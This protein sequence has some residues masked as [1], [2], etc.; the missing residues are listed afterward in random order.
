MFDL[1]DT[2][3]NRKQ[4]V[5]N[6]FPLIIEKCYK[7]IAL[8]E[9]QYCGMLKTFKE[10]DQNGRSDKIKMFGSLF[11]EFPPLYRLSDSEIKQFW[12][13]NFYDCFTLEN[14]YKNVLKQLKEHVKTAVITNGS[15]FSQ[16]SKI[17]NT[18][19]DEFF[20]VIIVS[21]EAELWKPDPKIFELALDKLGVSPENA[22]FVGDNLLTD[23]AGCQSAGIN[24]IWFN[25]DKAENNTDIKP[26][27]EIAEFDDV[28]KYL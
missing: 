6:I 7:N 19:L 14:E 23:I 10:Y 3:L 17:A 15:G 12:E 26:F 5:E 20:E 24:G 28:L 13:S 27:A 9:E 8:T 4:A 16:R 22:L 1:D 21:A 18:G 25:P 11:N 2:L